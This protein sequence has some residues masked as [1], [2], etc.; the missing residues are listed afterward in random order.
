[1]SLVAVVLLVI[2]ACVHAGWN[3]VGKRQH[4]TAAFF[5]IANAVGTACILPVL[6]YQWENLA[7]V[8]IPVWMRAVVSGFFYFIFCAALAGAYRTGDMSVAYPLALSSPVIFITIVAMI[9]SKGEPIG[10]WCLVGIMIV[11]LGCFILPMRRF[12]ELH[13]G[14]YLNACC[15][16]ALLSAIGTTGFTIADY[17]ALH[18]LRELPGQP[19]GPVDGP[20]TYVIFVSVSGSLCL[21]SFVLLNGWERKSFVEVFRVSKSS[22]AFMGIGMYLGYGLV[23]VS[24]QYVKNVSY[25]AAFRQLSIPLGATLGIVLLGEPRHFTTIV[26]VVTV[27]GGLVLVGMG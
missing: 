7:L 8:P 9:A 20:L 24:M 6:L 21:G 10:G 19:F 23:L 12:R 27:Y 4:P 15:L 3:L 22:A 1:M 11:A 14:N 26:G 2:S 5:L 25:V 18:I 16:L 17:E 13:L